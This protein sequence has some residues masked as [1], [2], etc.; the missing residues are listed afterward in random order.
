MLLLIIISIIFF[1]AVE[2]SADIF[3][4][5]SDDGVIVFTNVPLD[6]NSRLIMKETRPV[7][8]AKK[9]NSKISRKEVFHAIAEDKAKEYD[10]DPELVKAV[11]KA[12]SNWESDA[13]SSKGAIG[14]M[15]LM[16]STALY[17]GVVNPLDPIENVDGGIRYLKYLI[18]KFNGDISLALAAYNAGPSRIERFRSIPPISETITY[19]RKVMN[20]YAGNKGRDLNADFRKIKTENNNIRKIILEDGTVLFTNYYP[21][22]Y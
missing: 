5:V 2:S 19:V 3:K 18:K 10:I 6:R 17:M 4:N 7:N 14:L 1:G 8:N 13:I 12:E 11:I 16:P 9:E 20:M 21:A 22:Y 15:Q